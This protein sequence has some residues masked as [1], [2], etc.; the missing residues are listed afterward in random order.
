MKRETL[1][2]GMLPFLKRSFDEY[3]LGYNKI[4]NKILGM[5]DP[6]HKE[7]VF[8]ETVQFGAMAGEVC[9]ETF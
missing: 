1:S 2:L 8:V 6:E 9:K 5:N 4:E 3:R 7:T